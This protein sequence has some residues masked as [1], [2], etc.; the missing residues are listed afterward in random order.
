MDEL[1]A[2]ERSELLISL[3]PA[4]TPTSLQTAILERAGGNPLYLEQLAHVVRDSVSISQAS[5]PVGPAFLPSTLRL[6]VQSRAA[7]LPAVT[8]AILKLAAVAGTPFDP[9]LLA[10]VLQQTGEMMNLESALSDLVS[11]DFL[12][13]SSADYVFSHPLLAEVIYNELPT[14]ERQM[15]HRRLADALV[16]R[17]ASSPALVA[18]HRLRSTTRP[19]ADGSWVISLPPFSPHYLSQVV[20]A[21][22]TASEAAWQSYANREVLRWCQAG[23]ELLPHLVTTPESDVV[24]ENLGVALHTWM[25]KAFGRLGDFGPAIDYLQKAYEGCLASSTST[26][27]Q[28]QAAD[29]ARQVGR[30]RMRQG[31]YADSLTWMARGQELASGHNTPQAQAIRALIEVHTG[32]LYHWQGNLEQATEHYQTG[33][34]L[35]EQV[36]TPIFA[37]LAEGCNGLGVI[38]D[39]RGQIDQAIAYFTRALQ[40]WHTLGDRYEATRVQMNLGNAYFYRSDWPSAQQHYQ[41]SLAFWQRSEDRNHIPYSLLNLGGV[42]LAQG[43]WSEAEDC[44]TQALTLWENVGE[45]RLSALACINLGRLA[46]A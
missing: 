17:H 9:T 10:A 18:W 3:L 1:E 28:L 15:F 40:T 25:G 21:L 45:V 19:Q 11:R 20:E 36:H 43:R 5:F 35:A 32:A 39:E 4:N 16:E 12:R 33:I 29:L 14:V 24:A 30:L 37:A 27:R 6:T 2:E 44:Y 38:C 31:H 22:L 26:E 13:S 8:H 7:R 41:Q 42:Y 46:L 23:L 34:L